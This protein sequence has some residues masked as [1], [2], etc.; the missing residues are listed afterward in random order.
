MIWQ[1]G[2]GKMRS[3]FGLKEFVRD[4]NRVMDAVFGFA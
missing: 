4:C 2:V 3:S 1:D